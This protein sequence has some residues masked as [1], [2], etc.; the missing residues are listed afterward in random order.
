MQ[1]QHQS[2]AQGSTNVFVD[3][4]SSLAYAESA[5]DVATCL[6]PSH[7]VFS[8]SLGRR[9]LPE[10]H[11]SLQ[12]IWRCDAESFQAFDELVKNGTLARD[13]AGNSFSG[14]VAQAAFITSLVTC[15]AWVDIGPKTPPPKFCYR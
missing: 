13:I 5:L 11:L 8:V 14:T 4:S 15:G 12:G 3:C 9:L 7:G 2:Q 1:Y 6:A 10:E